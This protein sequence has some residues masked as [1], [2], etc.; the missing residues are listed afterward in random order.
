MKTIL[1][2][3]DNEDDAYLLKRAL[4][5]AGI[6]VEAQI[7]PDG[8]QALAYLKGKNHYGDRQRFPFPWLTLLDI[9]MPRK[10]GLEVLKEIRNDPGLTRLPV[11]LFT[12]SDEPR[13]IDRAFDLHANSYLV[14][15]AD[16]VSLENLLRKVEEYWIVLN[17]RPTCPVN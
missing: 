16:L 10:T 2:A 14:K 5:R 1:V 11:I 8:E 7:V 13:D 4:S 12:S 6:K 9:K 17:R 15:S 3:E